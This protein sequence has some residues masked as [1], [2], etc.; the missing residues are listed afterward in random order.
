MSECNNSV[1]KKDGEIAK[2]TGNGYA[3]MRQLCCG[4]T[5]LKASE[6]VTTDSALVTSSTRRLPGWLSG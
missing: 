5:G 1:H 3:S 6:W 2:I 4:I